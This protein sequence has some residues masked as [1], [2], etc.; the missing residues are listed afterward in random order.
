MLSDHRAYIVNTLLTNQ[1]PGTIMLILCS[2]FSQQIFPVI[3]E[4]SVISSLQLTVVSTK[5]ILTIAPLNLI[6]IL[7]FKFDNHS[8]IQ[9]ILEFDNH[10]QI[11][12][13]I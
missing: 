7:K 3:Y 9:Q 5:S 1:Q 8:Q 4:H 10:S 11:H 2:Y 13:Q 6:I 12:S